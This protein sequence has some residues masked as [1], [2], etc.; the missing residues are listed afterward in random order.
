MTGFPMSEQISCDDEFTDV[1]I[2]YLNWN[3]I[4]STET[5]A[6]TIKVSE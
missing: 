1:C 4:L 3:R 6:Q 5:K 2:I